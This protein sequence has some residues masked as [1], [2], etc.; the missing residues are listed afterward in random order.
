MQCAGIL[1]ILLWTACHRTLAPV[2]PSARTLQAGA[3]LVY[4]YQDTTE[5]ILH[6][7]KP[8]HIT[9]V[10]RQKMACKLAATFPDG[11]SRWQVNFLE[12]QN[13][14]LSGQQQDTTD[15]ARIYAESFRER[16]IA[17]LMR[18]PIMLQT[19]AAGNISTFEGLEP[20][21]R[22]LGDSLPPAERTIFREIS[23]QFGDVLLRDALQ[24]WWS[25]YPVPE[26]AQKEH[27]DKV[28]YYPGMGIQEKIR[29]SRRNSYTLQS[30]SRLI[31]RPEQAET[32]KIG[33][34]GVRYTLNGHAHKQIDIH[35][36]DGMMSTLQ[37]RKYL[38]GIM[39]IGV[40]FRAIQKVPVEMTV[41]AR[42]KRLE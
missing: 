17:A 22:R 7:A 6:Y 16:W 3:L 38:S 14:T 34:A 40:P 21:W 4:E 32:W 25:I 13:V 42:I 29:C 31:C 39:E 20:I 24:E 2:G 26:A 9:Q 5:T 19:D 8:Q 33:P 12:Y 18:H 10:N 23:R 30:K 36:G 37:S 35:P 11:S 1:F 27:W 28:L 15:G 41:F